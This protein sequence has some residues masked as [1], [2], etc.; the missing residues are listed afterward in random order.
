[1]GQ[2]E[3]TKRAKVAARNCGATIVQN[4]SL[5]EAAAKVRVGPPQVDE[6]DMDAPVWTGVLPM[7]VMNGVPVPD[8]L[9]SQDAPAYVYNWAE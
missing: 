2:D 6:K 7:E 3:K 4:M 1:L 5:T 9:N 8:V